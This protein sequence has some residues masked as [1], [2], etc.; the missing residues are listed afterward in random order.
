MEGLSGVCDI[1]SRIILQC[2]T[3]P[4]VC[5]TART[6]HI[7]PSIASQTVLNMWKDIMNMRPPVKEALCPV[8]RLGISLWAVLRAL[9][10]G[11]YPA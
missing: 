2:D 10:L 9:H 7:Q 4:L 6:T 3:V 11:S 8:S 5:D 1:W